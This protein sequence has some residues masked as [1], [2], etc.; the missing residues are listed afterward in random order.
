MS[1]GAPQEPTLDLALPV[2]Y[3]GFHQALLPADLGFSS[4]H[5]PLNQPCQHLLSTHCF[6]GEPQSTPQEQNAQMDQ[7]AQESG[8][9]CLLP[10]PGLSIGRRAHWGLSTLPK[11]PP[12]R[13]FSPWGIQMPSWCPGGRRQMM[14]TDVTST[15]A[16]QREKLPPVPT[17]GF[18]LAKQCHCASNNILSL[19]W[20]VETECI[21]QDLFEL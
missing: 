9:L 2:G 18:V 11:H 5:H 13:L 17:R 3:L 19:L 14:D 1:M 10:F 20:W 6:P 7:G 15:P 16:T 4:L 12:K 8:Q 21:N